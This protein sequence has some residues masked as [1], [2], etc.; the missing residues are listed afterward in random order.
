LNLYR[1]EA[2]LNREIQKENK[3]I[4]GKTSYTKKK[5]MQRVTDT[6]RQRDTL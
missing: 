1:K 6:E 5:K 3:D 4:D 2:F